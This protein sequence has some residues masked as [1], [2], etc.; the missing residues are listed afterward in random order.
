[1]L[2]NFTTASQ[3]EIFLNLLE[4][5]ELEFRRRQNFFFFLLLKDFKLWPAIVRIVLQFF[6]RAC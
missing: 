1:M 3:D 2:I 6:R 5:K 4:S